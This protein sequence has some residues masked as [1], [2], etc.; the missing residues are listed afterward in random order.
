M[1]TTSNSKTGESTADGLA[2]N[3]LVLAD[4]MRQQA[5]TVRDRVANSF[6]VHPEHASTDMLGFWLRQFRDIGESYAIDLELHADH[7]EGS[8]G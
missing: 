3:R 5:A 8:N 4:L 7:I 1:G 2:E 6:K